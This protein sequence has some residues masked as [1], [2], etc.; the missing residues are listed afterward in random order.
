MGESLSPG[1]GEPALCLSPVLALLSGPGV[2]VPVCIP[3]AGVPPPPPGGCIP[4][5][6]RIPPRPCIPPR[7]RI[8]PRPCVSPSPR[9]GA[10]RGGVGGFMVEGRKELESFFSE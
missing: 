1:A 3:G 10:V 9:L 6:P 2:C 5:H 4:P 8:P 7:P